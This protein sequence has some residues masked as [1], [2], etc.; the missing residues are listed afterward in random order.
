MLCAHGG[1]VFA[2]AQTATI[3]RARANG[4]KGTQDGKDLEGQTIDDVKHSGQDQSKAPFRQTWKWAVSFADPI[5]GIE[6]RAFDSYELPVDLRSTLSWAG[7]GMSGR[8]G[9]RI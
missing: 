8:W 5:S 7:G 1:S 6:Y 9:S 2:I 4:V 3:L